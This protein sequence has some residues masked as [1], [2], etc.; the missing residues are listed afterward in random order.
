[1]EFHIRLYKSISVHEF[2][3]GNIAFTYTL[4]MNLLC[5]AKVHILTPNKDF[6]IIFIQ[7][8]LSDTW[9]MWL[10]LIFRS[11]LKVAIVVTPLLAVTW[12]IGVLAINEHTSTLIATGYGKISHF[13]TRE[14]NRTEHFAMLP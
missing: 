4:Y 13:V 11:L 7:Y 8:S 1:M 3:T 5:Y 6:S 14:I 9:F 10:F 12:V 2:C